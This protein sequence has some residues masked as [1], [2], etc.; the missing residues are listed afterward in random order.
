MVNLA[1]WFQNFLGWIYENTINFATEIITR[2]TYTHETVQNVNDVAVFD[3]SLQQDK[4]GK[5]ITN[6]KYMK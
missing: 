6:I 3:S 2:E 4:R 5:T 1:V